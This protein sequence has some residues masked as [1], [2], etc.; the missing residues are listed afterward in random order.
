ML[1]RIQYQTH[2]RDNQDE[3]DS[4]NVLTEILMNKYMNR[5]ADVNLYF[6]HVFHF[7][8]CLKRLTEYL[9]NKQNLLTENPSTAF[10]LLFLS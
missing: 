10:P 7:V 9:K 2:K 3:S 4:L 5:V 1:H 6:R 8:V